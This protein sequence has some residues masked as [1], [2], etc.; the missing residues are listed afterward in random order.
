MLGMRVL[1]SL[2]EREEERG[3]HR[4]LERRKVSIRPGGYNSEGKGSKGT[5]TDREAAEIRRTTHLGRSLLAEGT[6]AFSGQPVRAGGVD[7]ASHVRG[8][9]LRGVAS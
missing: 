9:F 8:H 4:C 2:W 6:F 7:F 3:M 5:G 1:G